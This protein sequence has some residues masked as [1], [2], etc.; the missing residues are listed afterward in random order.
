M[1]YGDI[2]RRL[3]KLEQVA[4]I[5]QRDAAAE[6]DLACLDPLVQDALRS[7]RPEDRE[8]WIAGMT[9]FGSLPARGEQ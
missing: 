5:E 3:A 9:W 1:R 2:E 4:E 8:R 7:V 6:M